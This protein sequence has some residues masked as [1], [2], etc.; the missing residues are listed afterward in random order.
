MSTVC[1]IVAFYIANRDS[2]NISQARTYMD[3]QLRMLQKV[4]HSLNKVIFVV[5]SDSIK[6]NSLDIKEDKD[7]TYIYR[8]NK[9]LSFGSWCDTI[10]HLKDS[11]DYYILCEDDYVFTTDNFD[12]ILID[13]YKHKNAEYMVTYLN[14]K[15]YMST[16]G[17]LSKEVA[18]D[19]QYFSNLHFIHDKCKDMLTFLNNIQYVSIS[20]KYN[21]FPYWGYSNYA[22]PNDFKIQ[23]YGY[24]KNETKE[25]N[26]NRILLSCVQLLDENLE[27]DMDKMLYIWDSDQCITL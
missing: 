6:D 20:E 10:T 21:L 27:I 11:Y 8:R 14:S 9:G 25:S 16:I 5:S 22:K 24:D 17:I 7:I 26:K 1:L 23:L 3:I 13:E 15:G 12:K 4:K 19:K 2:C 18:R